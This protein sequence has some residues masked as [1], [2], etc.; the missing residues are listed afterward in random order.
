MILSPSE[1]VPLIAGL[2]GYKDNLL[3]TLINTS[4]F[5]MRVL[6]VVKD[7]KDSKTANRRMK[8]I[9][10]LHRYSD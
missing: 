2:T 10:H 8:L 7:Y 5:L 1:P 3:E 6:H 4:G 9:A